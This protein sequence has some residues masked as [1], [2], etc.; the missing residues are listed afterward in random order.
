MGPGNAVRESISRE[1]DE[2]I[3]AA[4]RDV[5]LT[6]AEARKEQN[7]T[8][9]Q[10]AEKIRIRQRYLVNLEEG[11]LSDLPGRVYILGFIRTY[12]RL[13]NLDEDEL[14]RRVRIL[15]NLQTSQRSHV[16][17]PMQM[18]EGPNFPILM[19]SAVFILLMGVGGYIFLKPTVKISS[20]VINETIMDDSEI[21][22]HGEE[23]DLAS[24]SEED[25]PAQ[26]L[27]LPTILPS[28]A[29]PDLIP[30]DDKSSIKRQT[31]AQSIGKEEAPD[32]LS[33]KKITLKAKEPAWIEIRGEDGHVIFMKVL[34]SGEVYVMPE[35]PGVTINTGNAGGIDIFVGDT[36]LP[37]LG[38]R[39]EVKRGIRLE[40]LQ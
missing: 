8:L 14:V 29:L 27:E 4:F 2:I 11:Q 39:G 35:K 6:L 32:A 22:P 13:L 33:P 34:K 12:A 16:P 21:H 5:G 1:P 10:V 40:T 25:S 9:K 37:P 20:S 30:S 38:A 24:F 26:P 7:L 31:L 15:P 36:Q 19:A 23:P 28:Q 18:D 3:L 17:T